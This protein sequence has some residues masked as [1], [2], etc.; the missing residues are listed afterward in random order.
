MMRP[1][2]RNVRCFILVAIA[3]APLASSASE[4][5]E[6]QERSIARS[7]CRFRDGR[8]WACLGI[9]QGREPERR[10]M[11]GPKPCGEV[12]IG[13][14]CGPQPGLEGFERVA[15]VAERDQR[16]AGLECG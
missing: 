12:G 1:A 2:A 14:G 5:V 13:V 3:L 4:R 10:G 11:A 16:A 7:H 8:Q 9:G 15:W 6:R